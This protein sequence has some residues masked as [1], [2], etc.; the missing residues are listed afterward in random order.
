[1]K[2]TTVEEL[3]KKRENSESLILLDV[4]E[5]HEYYMSDLDGT[6]RIPY[7][8]LTGRLDEIEKNKETEIIVLC[9]SGNSAGDAVKI[10]EKNGFSNVSRLTGGI[11]EWAAKIDPSIPQY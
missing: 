2:E 8:D 7:D 6:T 9:R 11:N 4:R 3:K 10:L 1:M 5:P